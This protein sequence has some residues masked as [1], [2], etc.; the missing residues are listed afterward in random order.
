MGRVRRGAAAPLSGIRFI[1]RNPR[2][3]RYFALPVLINTIV[4]GAG[5]YIFFSKLPDL[6]NWIFGEPEVWYMK[7][8]FFVAGIIIAAVFAL[9]LMF[10]FTAL[11]IVVAGPF[12][13]VLSRKVD[14][15]RLGMDPAPEGGSFLREVRKVLASQVKKLLLFVLVQGL[16][17][18]AYLVPL[19]GEIVGLPLQVLVTFFFLAWEFWDFPMERRKMDFAAKK[20]FLK[21]Y[22]IE[23]VSFGA[24][25]F[26]YMM[27]PLLNFILMP[28]SVAG[29]TV[30]VSDLLEEKGPVPNV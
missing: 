19:I 5:A 11:G 27:V 22:K 8:L 25:C 10:T 13:D 28:A 9:F 17:L 16:L 7:A 15:I 30:L 2:L 14:E 24:V 21:K 29:A 18:F 26:F 12:L 23:A 3:V 20:D 6:L 4:Y 1:A